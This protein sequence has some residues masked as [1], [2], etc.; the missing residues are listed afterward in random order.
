MSFELHHTFVSK[1]FTPTRRT[2]DDQTFVTV[3][4]TGDFQVLF[5]GRLSRR[6]SAT[7]SQRFPVPPIDTVDGPK[8]PLHGAMSGCDRKGDALRLD[9]RA[10]GQ[11]AV[12]QV[13]SAASTVLHCGKP[14]R[15]LKSKLQAAVQHNSTAAPNSRHCI[16]RALFMVSNPLLVQA[17][18]AKCPP[19]VRARVQ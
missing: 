16:A 7:F 12:R 6:L 14:F 8:E 18:S 11:D 4:E 13:G 2:S 5:P 15:P 9:P 3:D 1:R 10:A 17:S 19:S